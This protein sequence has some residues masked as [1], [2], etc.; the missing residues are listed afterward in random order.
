[1]D[2][3]NPHAK[4][5]SEIVSW[6]V[7]STMKYFIIGHTSY[8]SDQ[9]DSF[10]EGLGVASF[11]GLLRKRWM[12]ILLV[13][14]M[15]A[16]AVETIIIAA[17]V[18][19]WSLGNQSFP[20]FSFNPPVR[21]NCAALTSHLVSQNSQN[22]TALFDCS[23]STQTMAAF[24][25]FAPLTPTYTHESGKPDLAEPVFTLPPGYL[26]LYIT[27]DF[28]IGS[29]VGPIPLTS[30][31]SLYIGMYNNEYD[32]CAEISNSVNPASSFHIDWVQGANPQPTGPTTPGLRFAASPSN[33]TISAGESATSSI[34][35]ISRWFKGPLY[36]STRIYPPLFIPNPPVA[37]LDTNASSIDVNG[38]DQVTLTIV[39]TTNTTRGEFAI[40]VVVQSPPAFYEVIVNVKIT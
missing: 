22:R 35:I 21:V 13:I 30:K 19:N 4:P 8:C 40:H 27:N 1:M 17:I 29:C 14:V 34:E 25:V 28:S 15:I 16:L 39:S 20:R 37:S 33:M 32:Y 24:T 2:R 31:Q 7:C 5:G 3:T 12:L 23:T 9:L 36:L 38:S 11:T 10:N 26:G 18:Y 6:T